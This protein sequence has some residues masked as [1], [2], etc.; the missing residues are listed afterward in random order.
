MGSLQV[1]CMEISEVYYTP[2]VLPA[3]SCS[4]TSIDCALEQLLLWLEQLK[5]GSCQ[6]S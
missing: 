1:L 4:C 5:N 6:A 3:L 2:D